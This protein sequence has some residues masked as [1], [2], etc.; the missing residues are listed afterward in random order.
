[1]TTIILLALL[2]SQIMQMFNEWSE[3]QVRNYSAAQVIKAHTK[4][5][6]YYRRVLA[7]RYITGTTMHALIPYAYLYA[8]AVPPSS[9]MNARRADVCALLDASSSRTLL[10]ALPIE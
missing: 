6:H 8:A 9:E 5:L 10:R 7:A 4:R 2:L 1:M 3:H